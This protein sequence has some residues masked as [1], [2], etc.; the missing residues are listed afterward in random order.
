MSSSRTTS[1]AASRP[2]IRSTIRAR[3]S[4]YLDKVLFIDGALVKVGDP[5]FMIDQRPY[6]AALEQADATVSS[7]QVRDWSSPRTISIVPSSCASPATSPSSSSTSAAPTTSRPRRSRPRQA[8][9]RQARLDMEFTEIKA[10]VAGRISRRL[11]SVGNLVNANE[12]V[13]T[14]SS[15]SIRSSSIRRRRAL[16]S[17]IIRG[18]AIGLAN[19]EGKINALVAMTNE[20]EGTRKARSTSS[21]TGSTRRAAPSAPAPCSITRTS[22]SRLGCS[23]A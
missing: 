16:L 21:T 11:V 13:L 17:R 8:T 6:K 9:Q 4:G 19:A 18:R 10:P 7:S 1:S 23:A 15:P 12:T 5:L 3:V 22:F 14:K 2:S 20:R